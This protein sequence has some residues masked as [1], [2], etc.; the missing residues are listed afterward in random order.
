MLSH[1]CSKSALD[2]LWTCIVTLRFQNPM[3]RHHI[4]ITIVGDI[5]YA[6]SHFSCWRII[7]GPED[8]RPKETFAKFFENKLSDWQCV[9]GAV[10]GIVDGVGD[11]AGIDAMLVNVTVFV[12]PKFTI[13]Y[14]LDWNHQ[15]IY[16]FIIDL[17]T[18]TNLIWYGI[19]SMTPTWEF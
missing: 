13:L 12:I 1:I 2:C 7:L 19:K 14:G 8:L 9:E 5:S 15:W 17:L 4:P 18:C 11:G 16:G 6:Q 3:V 10:L